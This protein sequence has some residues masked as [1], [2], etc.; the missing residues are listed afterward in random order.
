ML[1]FLLE[2]LPQVLG[3]GELAQ[4][5]GLADTLAIVPNRLIFVVEIEP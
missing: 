5:F 2:D 1:L 3:D 4:R